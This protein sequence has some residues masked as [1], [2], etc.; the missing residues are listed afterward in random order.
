METV[1]E[2]TSSIFGG[3]RPVDTSQREKEIEERL[4]K[5]EDMLKT[6]D[7]E[8]ENLGSGSNKRLESLGNFDRP[9]RAEGDKESSRRER[10]LSSN[11]SQSKG[12]KP[13]PLNQSRTRRDSNNSNTSEVYSDEKEEKP[14]PPSPRKEDAPAKMVPAPPPKENI[15]ERRKTEQKSGKDN[16]YNEDRNYYES[17][18][19]W[20][21]NQ[22]DSNRENDRRSISTDDEHKR[23]GKPASEKGRNPREKQM[24]KSYEEMPQYQDTVKKDWTDA[25]KFNYLNNEDDEDYQENLS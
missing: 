16:S 23:A 17:S 10:R 24:P 22:M 1:P 13:A 25:N 4:R 11:S 5:Q 18:N 7:E 9:Y 19:K 6:R 3:A 2:K 21:K 12:I 8:K 15:W 20:K 14:A